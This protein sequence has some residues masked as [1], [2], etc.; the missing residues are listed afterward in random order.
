MRPV[1]TEAEVGVA[2]TDRP[3]E[4]RE[5]TEHCRLVGPYGHFDEDSDRSVFL[6]VRDEDEEHVEEAGCEVEA[7]VYAL[8]ELPRPDEEVGCLVTGGTPE[9]VQALEEHVEEVVA[10]ALLPA[11]DRDQ[12]AGPV[13]APNDA[14]R[15]SLIVRDDDG[16]L[17]GETRL[18]RH[19]GVHVLAH[20]AAEVEDVDAYGGGTDED[21]PAWLEWIHA[22]PPMD[23]MVAGARCVECGGEASFS[24]G[25]AET[26]GESTFSRVHHRP[27]CDHASDED[28]EW[29]G[30][31]HVIGMIRDRPRPS[32]M[33]LECIWQE[34]QD[35]RDLHEKVWLWADVNDAIYSR[36]RSMREVLERRVV[37]HYP[38][39]PNCG[40]TL[41]L[42]H[43]WI[44]QCRSCYEEVPHEVREKRRHEESRLWGN[45][46]HGGGRE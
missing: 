29:W 41:D 3:A 22:D 5:L 7:G 20:V 28:R 23:H 19:G 40:S 21:P 18:R 16:E 12:G 31:H 36:W 2:S 6:A 25:M 9:A 11:W 34:A 33:A 42:D 15:A 45:A 10:W 32:A 38:G 43:E 44:V 14:A 46:G 13:T 8:V 24:R 26:K 37:P 30:E 39:C 27:E 17:K 4:I 35:L 1:A